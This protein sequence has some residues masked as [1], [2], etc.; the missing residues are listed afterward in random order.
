MRAGKSSSCRSCY[1][2]GTGHHQVF[3]RDSKA[4]RRSFRV[5]KRENP[6]MLSFEEI[7]LEKLEAG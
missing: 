1:T 2:K 6:T 4:S 7:G 5:E 3:G